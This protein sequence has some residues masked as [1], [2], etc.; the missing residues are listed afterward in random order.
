MRVDFPREEESLS[1]Q[2][3]HIL[4]KHLVDYHLHLLEL[5]SKCGFFNWKLAG[6]FFLSI[7]GAFILKDRGIITDPLITIVIMGIACLFG[8]A[9]NIKMDLEYASRAADCVEKGTIIEK[10]Y[11]YSGKLFG[12]FEDNKWIVYRGN[13]L[14][15]FF[16]IGL[17]GVLAAG[18]GTI[19]SIKVGA[20]LAVVVATLSI[21][22]LSIAA[23][24]Y[25]KNTRRILLGV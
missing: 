22:A 5:Q 14:S 17:V 4:Y 16:P 2:D 11:D 19:L 13:L 18:A 23:R 25:T 15:R 6:I 7:L 10:K 24:S 20:W 1:P 3:A 12:I 21:V 9:Q 8:F